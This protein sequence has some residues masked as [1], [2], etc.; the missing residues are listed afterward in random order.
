MQKDDDPFRAFDDADRTVYVPTPGGRRRGGAA[1]EPEQ[2]IADAAAPRRGDRSRP[3]GEPL[4]E[5]HG[6]NPLLRAAA[7]LFALV[8]Q[9]RQT[10][11]HDD[12]EGLRRD[13]IASIRQFDNEAVQA[14]VSAKTA[15][16]ATYALCSLID[17]TVLSTPWGSDS[18]WA[19]KSL[20]ITFYKEASAGE[21]FFQFLKEARN[22]PKN[23]I[24]LLELF[25]V[26]LSLGFQGRYRPQDRGSDHLARIRQEVLAL[27]RQQRGEHERE[28]SP[29]WRGIEDRRPAVSRFVPLWVAGAVAGAVILIAF[30]GFNLRLNE[31]SDDVYNKIVALVPPSIEP[32]PLVV[33]TP[34]LRERPAEPEIATEPGLVP[35]LQA[36]LANE[37]DAGLLEVRDLGSAADIVFSSQG[38]FPSG[39]AEVGPAVRPIL[40]KIGTFLA[41]Y[42]MPVTISGHTD[43]VPIRTIRFPSNYHLSKAR[44]ESV[45]S[46]LA[47]TIGNA[48][49][50][51]IEAR[52]DS[53][54]VADNA[55]KEGQALNRRVEIRVPVT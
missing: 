25:Y 31:A 44:A 53:E 29:R 46:L 5:G 52:A 27:I 2:P 13:V 16:Q 24:D 10:R 7:P 18:I 1:A 49:R 47:A 37:I 6:A 36:L 23:N 17:E 42:S 54:P 21:T 32:R 28:L 38:L 35:K 19:K 15:A 9:L 40:D 22:Y 41:G 43:N 39:G 51:K 11:R 45:A 4:P 50:L 12:V 33:A 55:T 14:G 8:R 20:L 26:C 34:P 3:V 48:D 30:V